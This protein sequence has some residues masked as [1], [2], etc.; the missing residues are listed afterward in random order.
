MS[1]IPNQHLPDL[2]KDSQLEV[3][4]YNSQQGITVHRRRVERNVQRDAHQLEKWVRGRKPLGKGGFGIVWFEAVM[5]NENEIMRTRA[6]KEI[7][8]ATNQVVAT[9]YLR[10]LEAIAKFSHEKVRNTG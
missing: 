6:V 2:V 8:I 1:R 10:E 3:T 5:N 9:D 4:Y 7:S